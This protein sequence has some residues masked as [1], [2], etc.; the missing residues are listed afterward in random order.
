MLC[1]THII[2]KVIDFPY[3]TFVKRLVML[4]LNLWLTKN[5]ATALCNKQP[6]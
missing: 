2:K 5:I 4:D 3:P 6:N 1:A